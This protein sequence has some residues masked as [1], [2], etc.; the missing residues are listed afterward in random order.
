LA[1]RS[2]LERLFD[3]LNR[4]FFA[5]RLPAYKVRTVR[6][7]TD[8]VRGDQRGHCEP[9]KQTILV[10]ADLDSAALRQVLLHEMCHHGAIGHGRRWQA[11][12]RRLAEFGETWAGT[13]ADAYAEAGKIELPLTAQIRH[14]ISDIAIDN[15]RRNGMKSKGF[16]FRITQELA[17]A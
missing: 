14:G 4:Q 6:R 13:E 9:K 7:F 1:R 11:K 17:L 8:Q 16:S 12:M 3:R 10:R 5:G 15:P 2:K